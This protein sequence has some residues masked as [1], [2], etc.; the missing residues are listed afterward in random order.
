MRRTGVCLAVA[1][2]ILGGLAW[3]G[4]A[5]AQSS[6]MHGDHM[7]HMAAAPAAGGAPTIAGL[8]ASVVRQIGDAQKKLTALAE[9]MPA[10]KYSWRPGTGVRSVGEVYMHVAAAN[11]LFGSKSGAKGPEGVNPREFEKDGGDKAKTLAALRQSFD[12]LNQ[13]IA[14]L[15]DADLGRSIDFFGRQMTTWD[16]VVIAATHA[17]EHLGQSIAYAR[18][19]GVVPPWSAAPGKGND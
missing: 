1:T 16:V 13:A 6:S 2:L 10:E 19:N 18:S 17:H 15:S 12:Y 7:D 5:A 8:R 14:A 4:S 9:A 11:Y 3:A